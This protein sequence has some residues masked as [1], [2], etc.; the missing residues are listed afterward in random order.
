[1]A[2]RALRLLWYLN[3][4]I[5]QLKENQKNPQVFLILWYQPLGWFPSFFYLFYL[6]KFF[7]LFLFFFFFLIDAWIKSANAALPSAFEDFSE[8]SSIRLMWTDSTYTQVSFSNIPLNK[9]IWLDR[10]YFSVSPL[11]AVFLHL[12]GNVKEL[13]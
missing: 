7:G 1:M 11:H 4:W 10:S 9:K 6:K 3:S 8:L 5:A 12:T 2:E 13:D